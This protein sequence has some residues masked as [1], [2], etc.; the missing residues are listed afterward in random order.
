MAAVDYM[1]N[2]HRDPIS[3]EDEEKW[4][5]F[6]DDLKFLCDSYG[7]DISGLKTEYIQNPMAWK[8]D[9]VVTFKVRA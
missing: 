7:Y 5:S 2:T 9:R 4:E 6:V 1:Y 3:N 8:T